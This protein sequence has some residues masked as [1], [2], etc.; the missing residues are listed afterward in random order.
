MLSI[1]KSPTDKSGLGYVAPPYDIPSTS[2][3][4]FVKPAVPEPP[5]IVED[6]GKDKINGDVPST[7]K[8]PTIRKSPICHH[9]G[10]RVC[11]TPVLPPQSSKSKGQEKS[12]Q[13]SKLRHKTSSPASDS[14]A[15]GSLSSSLLSPMA[16][17]PKTSCPKAPGSST[18]AALAKICSCKS[19]G[20][21]EVQQIQALQ[22]AAEGGG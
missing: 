13:T 20:Q 18:S 2:R 9:C 4:V 22:K 15:S 11:P 6:K 17:R 3:T 1:Q 10:Q 8:P 7:Q 5:P 19:K 12:S 14:M 21:I 16:S